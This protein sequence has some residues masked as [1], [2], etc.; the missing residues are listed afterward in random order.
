[1]DEETQLVVTE[2]E[3]VPAEVE[4]EAAQIIAALELI[5]SRMG[6]RAPHPATK[7]KVRGARTVSPDFVA[8]LA[9]SADSLP[10]LRTCGTF[11][12]EK[13]RLA[14]KRRTAR[15]LL[16]E[17]VQIFL[18]ML[19]Y[20]AEAEWA[21]GRRRGP[22][23]LRHRQHRR[24]EGGAGGAGGARRAAPEAPGAVESVEGE[25]EGKDAEEEG[26]GVRGRFLAVFAARNDR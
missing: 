26:R 11:D 8:G 13:A 9:A 19:K 10:V 16:A 25:A 2:G 23:D 24:R 5:A 17:R 1:V 22:G 6:L 4:R 12:P 15:R 21:E 14:I 18:D 7:G 3:D 20:T